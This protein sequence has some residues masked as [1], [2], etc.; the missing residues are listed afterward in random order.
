MKIIVLYNKLDTIHIILS[1]HKTNST[2]ILLWIHVHLGTYYM[3][4]PKCVHRRQFNI[5]MF[6]VFFKE[7]HLDKVNFC[8]P[9]H[10]SWDIQIT[11]RFLVTFWL[12]SAVLTGAVEKGTVLSHCIVI[13]SHSALQYIQFPIK[14][15]KA[16]L[17]NVVVL[18]IFEETR[19]VSVSACRQQM[20][21]VRHE[22]GMCFC[23][24][25][26]VQK[27]KEISPVLSISQFKK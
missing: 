22:T 7:R 19:D 18:V 4:T 15:A 17:E 21:N 24:M 14:K 2:C 25:Y 13:S 1:Y 11:A 3:H 10:S 16:M 6:F 12:H 8:V 5:Y 9:L 27:V 26:N 20:A 23:L